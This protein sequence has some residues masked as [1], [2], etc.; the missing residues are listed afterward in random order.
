[1]PLKEKCGSMLQTTHWTQLLGL[2]VCKD[3]LSTHDL[4]Q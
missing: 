2:D 3:Y 4:L 1:M